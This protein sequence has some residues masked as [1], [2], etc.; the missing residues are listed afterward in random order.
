MTT[1]PTPPQIINEYTSAFVTEI[2]DPSTS[3]SEPWTPPIRQNH[4]RTTPTNHQSIL[5]MLSINRVA[6]SAIEITRRLLELFTSGFRQHQSRH[7]LFSS[8]GRT[9]DIVPSPHDPR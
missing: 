9:I 3:R 5:T 6:I 1:P 7:R 4:H 2:D 8:F